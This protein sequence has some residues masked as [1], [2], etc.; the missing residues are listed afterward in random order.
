M[1]G[2]KIVVYAICK[3][4]GKFVDRWMDSMGEADLVVVTDTGSTDDT[5][6][7]LIARG[8]TVFINEVKPWRFDVAR[9]LSLE[10]VQEDADICV[11][12]DLDE[13]FEKGWRTR[14]EA[15]WKPDVKQARYIFNWSLKEDGTPY[16]Q[17]HYAKVHARHGFVWRD[18]VHEWLSYVGKEPKISVFVEG[19]VL[20]HYPDPA[21]SRGSYLP[22]L[23]LGVAENPESDRLRYYLGREYMYKSEWTK[24]ID[25]LKEYLKLPS[26]T[27][28]E[29]R[30]AAMRWIA[31][32]CLQLK[33]NKEAYAWYLRA[34]AEAPHMRD[35]YVECAKMAYQIADW[36]MSFFMAEEALKIKERSK[37][38]VNMGYSWDYTPHDLAAIACYRLAMYERALEHADAALRE[39]PEDERLKN[40]LRLIQAKVNEMVE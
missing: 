5:V 30:S 23:E 34:I 31:K 36:P 28:N 13:L 24:C 8:A 2:Y 6:E 20:N 25:T 27:W 11:C 7:R 14:L 38:Y 21:K 18:P 10:N 26:A 29:E 15:A 16:V 39:S 19:M 40:N 32:S 33:N 9:N 17:M 4:E 3:N 37:T 12:T 1:A 22:L 35:P